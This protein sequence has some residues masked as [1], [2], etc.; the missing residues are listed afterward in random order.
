[1]NGAFHRL[2]FNRG[3]PDFIRCFN[4]DSE[5]FHFAPYPPEFCVHKKEVPNSIS[6]VVLR[7]SLFIC[8]FSSPLC[9][10]DNEGL[11]HSGILD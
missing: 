11:C 10:E 2:T 4:F 8:D 9:V 6:L 7:D 5:Q 3:S 1:M